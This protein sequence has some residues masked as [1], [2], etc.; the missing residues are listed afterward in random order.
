MEENDTLAGNLE[1]WQNL[2]YAATFKVK[3]VG[4]V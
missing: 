2:R 3:K 4:P 1:Q